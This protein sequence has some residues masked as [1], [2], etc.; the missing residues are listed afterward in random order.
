MNWT[1]KAIRQLRK[2][3]A[4]TQRRLAAE[5]GIAP[6]WMSVM[7]RKAVNYNKKFDV[8]LDALDLERQSLKPSHWTAKAL[9]KFKERYGVQRKALAAALDTTV[10]E[11]TRLEAGEII[12]R[13]GS[14][15][16][17]ILDEIS[18][19]VVAGSATGCF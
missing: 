9:C 5:L 17:K 16:E 10:Y 3:L 1:P 4:W 15:A 8:I 12:I 7:E 6:C 13:Q 11:C 2:D 19:A 14:E 18:A